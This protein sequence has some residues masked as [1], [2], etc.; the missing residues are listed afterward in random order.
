MP[1]NAQ[2]PFQPIRNE[3]YSSR[4]LMT[5]FDAADPQS[6]ARIPDFQVFVYFVA[7]GRAT[8]ADPYASMMEGLHD[9]SILRAMFRFLHDSKQPT[10]A[11]MGGHKEPRG[12]RAYAAVVEISKRLAEVGFLMASG[13][14]PGAMEAT[15]LGA[16]LK[17]QDAATVEEAIQLLATEAVLPDS[18]TIV[19]KDGVIDPKLVAQ[20]HR[21]AVPAAKLLDRFANGGQSLAVPTWHYGHEPLT[22]LATHVAKY[23]LNSIREDVLLALATNA[24]LIAND[25]PLKSTQ[26]STTAVSTATDRFSA[27]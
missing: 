8:P 9:N 1:T 7:N 18:A 27:Q 22:P 25:P 16:L 5:G 4:E 20:I 11:I 13:G 15:H 2:L 21:W 10:A 23:F 19:D 3:L 26:A 17:G 12:S 14:G 24:T 6:M